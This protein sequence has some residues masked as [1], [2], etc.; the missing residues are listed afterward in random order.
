MAKAALQLYSVWQR[1]QENP[2]RTLEEAA[3]AGYDG[4]EFAGF[5]D[6]PAEEMRK[7]LDELGL[8]V[9][10][11]HTA[12]DLM[13]KDLDAVLAYNKTIGNDLIIIPYV[14]PKLRSKDY[15]M[16]LA[17]KMNDYGKRIKEQGFT[18]A[19]HNHDFEFVAY[20][21]V[22]AYDMLVENTDPEY[23]KFQADMGWVSFAGE[24]TDAFIKKY[25][26]RIITIHVKQFKAV[27]DPTGTE[28]D[29]GMVDYKPIVAAYQK[30]GVQWFIIEQESY[31]MPMLESIAISS[32][33]L[34]N[35]F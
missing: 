31:D 16:E 33:A 7:K 12:I 9:C 10:G 11:S 28:V 21:G 24:D 17:A 26:E 19:Y 1:M 2:L 25:G 4:V 34:K 27:G 13:D 5:F 6:V 32:K 15:Y 29:R 20:D 8:E 23:V 30:L 14:D 3:A 18:L 22:T 35:M